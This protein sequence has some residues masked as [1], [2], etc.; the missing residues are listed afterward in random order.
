MEKIYRK[1]AEQL[2]LEEDIVKEAY[3]T[4][5][6]FIRKKIEALPLKSDLSEEEF[7]KLRTSFNIPSLGKLCCT[8]QRFLNIKKK[9][10][11]NKSRDD[12]DK[13]N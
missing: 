1:V 7:S 6:E 5:W 13:E 8:Y 10:T 4:Y 3:N 11:Y 9:L 12:K 2:N